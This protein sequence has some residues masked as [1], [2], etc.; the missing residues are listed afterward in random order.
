MVQQLREGIEKWESMKLLQN[1]RNIHQIEEWEEF[2]GGY[3][4]DIIGM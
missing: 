1:K 3:T 4:F 2:S